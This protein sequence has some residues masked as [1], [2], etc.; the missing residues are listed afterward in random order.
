MELDEWLDVRGGPRLEQFVLYV[1][2]R[3]RAAPSSA[4]G[5]AASAIL[6]G[7]APLARRHSVRVIAQLHRPVEG[8]AQTLKSRLATALLWG[9]TTSHAVEDI[10]LAGVRGDDKVAISKCAR[11][12]FANDGE[13]G[14]GEVRDVTALL[15]DV[16]EVSS[17]LAVS[18]GIE[19]A[20][21]TH[22][23]QLVACCEGTLRFAVVQPDSKRTD[24]GGC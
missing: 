16:G 17:W 15:G 3:L 22:R 21:Q 7:W 4:D 10:W 5:E 1:G 8:D 9:Q 23:P 20:I 13:S 11:Q 12:P 24:S 6:L 18:L 14:H 19:S 2:V